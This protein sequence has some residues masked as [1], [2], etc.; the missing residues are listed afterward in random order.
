MHIEGHKESL[1]VLNKLNAPS[2]ERPL[3]YKRQIVTH[4][5]G[6]LR[7]SARVKMVQRR[8]ERG[9]RVATLSSLGNVLIPPGAT[10]VM[11][12]AVVSKHMYIEI[13]SRGQIDSRWHQYLYKKSLKNHS[14]AYWREVGFTLE[15]GIEYC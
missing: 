6:M 14:N 5:P 10:V 12:R 3:S 2:I 8:K 11:M 9:T 4:Y 7:A 13:N 15:V 1:V